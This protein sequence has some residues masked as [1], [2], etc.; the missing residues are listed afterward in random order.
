MIEGTDPTSLRQNGRLSELPIC[1][2]CGH[3][4]IL[5]SLQL[6]FEIRSP[7][8]ESQTKPARPR[9]STAV[10]AAG[11]DETV[12]NARGIAEGADD[13]AE[14]IDESVVA[15]AAVGEIDVGDDSIA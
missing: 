5:P 1:C 6:P 11:S 9:E 10:A 14:V 3:F 7:R 8:S 12:L 15:A 2:S 13:Q 4:P